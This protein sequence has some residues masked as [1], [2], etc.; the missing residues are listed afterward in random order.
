MF[1]NAK[2]LCMIEYI[3]D[4]IEAN[5]DAFK[6]EGRMKD[7]L[8]VKTVASC[9]KEAISSYY[10]ATFSKKKVKDWLKRLLK[11]YNRGFHTG[12]YFQN[13]TPSDI[14]LNKRGN[15]SPHKKHY[16]GRIL[17]YNEKIKTAELLIEA[18]SLP[19]IEG[20]EF[21]IEGDDTYLLEKFNNLLLHGTQ[22]HSIQ[23]DKEDFPIKI[24]VKLE[25]PVLSGDK[26]YKFQ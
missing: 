9:Y 23:R 14:Q 18:K 11:V 19:I 26:I 16:I 20:N 25:N 17:T 1:L 22:I 10:D 24:N 4:L 7:P 6:I 12:F 13:P 21:I 2:D 5:I 8:Y 15:I 3:P